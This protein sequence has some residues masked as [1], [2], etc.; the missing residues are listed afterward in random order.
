MVEGNGIIPSQ[1]GNFANNWDTSP[2]MTSNQ[3]QVVSSMLQ[4]RED[5]FRLPMGP[6]EIEPNQS[7]GN[8]N[9]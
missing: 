7:I 6:T 9:L 8:M 4:T 5:P 3:R 2:K 1:N